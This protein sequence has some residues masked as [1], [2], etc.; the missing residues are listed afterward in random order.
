MVESSQPRRRRGKRTSN[1]CLPCRRSKIKC[2]GEDPCAS[3]ERRLVSCRFNDNDQKVVVSETYAKR[4]SVVNVSPMTVEQADD[5]GFGFNVT[6]DEGITGLVTNNSML[7]LDGS[8]HSTMPT[9]KDN[10]DQSDLLPGQQ[11]ESTLSIWPSAFKMAS[12]TI[13]NT[14]NNRRKWIWLAPWSTWSF[15]LRLMLILGESLKSAAPPLPKQM[16]EDHA[17][18]LFNTVKFHLGQTYRFFDDAELEAQIREFYFGHVA[19]KASESR[20]WFTKFLLV[21]AFG[22][23]FHSRPGSSESRDPPGGKFFVQAMSI[24]P[25]NMSLWRDSLMATEV[26]AMIGLY[27]FSIDERESAHVYVSETVTWCRDLWWTLYIMDRHFSASVG[28][29][30]S[31]HDSEIT[32]PI[33]PPNH[34]SHADSLRS[35][36]VKLSHLMSMILRTVYKP[37]KTSLATYVEQT[38]STLHTLAQYAQE[39][40]NIMSVKFQTSVDTVPRGMRH[41]TLLYHQCVIVATRP[42]LISILKERLDMVDNVTEVDWES[43]LS[44]TGGIISSGIKSASKTL[45]VLSSEYSLLE[46]FLP[47]NLEFTYGAAL[48]IAMAG[49]IFPD[50]SE[51]HTNNKAAHEILSDMVTRGNRVAGVRRT[52]LLHVELMFEKLE[53]QSN[54]RG[55]CSLRLSS[56][57]DMGSNPEEDRQNV[58]TMEAD[59]DAAAMITG[60]VGLFPLM[61]SSDSTNADFLDLLDSVGI[62]SEEFFSITQG[63]GDIEDIPEGVLRM[64]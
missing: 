49:A 34:G 1:A 29:P 7:T 14:R 12:Q 26:L 8:P 43:I 55:H 35:L 53:E 20:L 5:N 59:A 46:V 2:N 54:S 19:Q 52:E 4:R 62:S 44:H 39:L 16:L 22:T 6:M 47:Y 18:Y 50:I 11:P 27:L 51:N 56:V 23:A 45:Q 28:L 21:L 60:A 40:E 64:Y 38:K 3:C 17:F 31:V 48:H 61:P 63:M 30:M 10:A 32:T 36:Q 15:T 33:N 9:A 42:L 25:D 57:M 24:L 37:T 13:K 41:I 58:S